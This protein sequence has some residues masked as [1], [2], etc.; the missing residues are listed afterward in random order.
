MSRSG[1]YDY[2]VKAAR[3][4]ALQLKSD[5]HNIHAASVQSL[6]MSRITSANT[7]RGHYDTTLRMRAL[8]RRAHDA[9]SRREPDGI[10]DAE[11]DALLADMGKEL[12]ETT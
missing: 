11:W 12:G 2:I 7:S 8:L 1:K 9:M 3:E 6:I 5:G 4:A 10:R